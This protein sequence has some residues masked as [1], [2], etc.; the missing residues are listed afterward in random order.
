M[1][2]NRKFESVV[3][4]ELNYTELVSKHS[5][6]EN[7]MRQRGNIFHDDTR[8]LHQYDEMPLTMKELGVEKGFDFDF[9]Y[10]QKSACEFNEDLAA[11]HQSMMQSPKI[12]RHRKKKRRKY[13]KFRFVPSL[14]AIKENE[15][16]ETHFESIR[17]LEKD[18]RRASP[19]SWYVYNGRRK[20]RTSKKRFKKFECKDVIGQ[21]D[22]DYAGQRKKR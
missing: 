4:E 7:I 16:F 22:Y 19:E 13:P 10:G 2:R 8:M 3:L 20:T 12:N 21:T 17:K 9:K 5:V 1:Q 6:N 15:L 14:E 11:I 18:S